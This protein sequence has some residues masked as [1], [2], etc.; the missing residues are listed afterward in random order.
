MVDGLNMSEIAGSK[1]WL[2]HGSDSYLF[3]TE[4]W[5]S[6]S[7]TNLFA[8]D[9]L[10]RVT[11]APS[12]FCVPAI[13][14][15]H[16]A[17]LPEIF[18]IHICKTRHLKSYSRVISPLFLTSNQPLNLMVYLLNTSLFFPFLCTFTMAALIQATVSKF[19]TDNH[20]CEAETRN[21]NSQEFPKS[22]FILYFFHNTSLTC[23]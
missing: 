13:S 15:P 6:I 3:A 7:R 9:T 18:I 11:Q 8:E 12:T 20:F 16:T 22:Q 2:A 1:C 5:A 19:L 23:F 21:W 17:F 4:S 14:L 10:K